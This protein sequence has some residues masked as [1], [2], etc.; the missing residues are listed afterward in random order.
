MSLRD[1]I[2]QSSE[3]GSICSSICNNIKFVDYFIYHIISSY[4]NLFCLFKL[5]LFE[6]KYTKELISSYVFYKK[7][8]IFQY[9]FFSEGNL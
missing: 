6:M 7:K 2:N 9:L 1:R 3:D 8:N 5:N 4:F